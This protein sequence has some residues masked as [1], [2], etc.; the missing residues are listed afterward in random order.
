MEKA[1]GPHL[2]SSEIRALLFEIG[3][4]LSSEGLVAEIAIYGGS[5]LVLVGG[6]RKST[7]DM[8]FVSLSGDSEALRRVADTVGARHGLE[9]GWL[10]DAVSIFASETPDYRTIGDFPPE[11]PGLRVFAASPRY[12]L[13]MKLRSMRSPFET[14]DFPDI[15]ELADICGIR[16]A[17]EARDWLRGF[18]PDSPMP[19]HR[20]L[21]LDDIFAAKAA[22][23]AYDSRLAWGA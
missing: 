20:S 19:S 14:N 13:A 17:D 8:D 4:G 10:N 23:Q 7:K 6:T 16:S 5:A 3:E 18:Y 11:R 15:W 21:I 12:L 1:T 2:G 22:G 9:S